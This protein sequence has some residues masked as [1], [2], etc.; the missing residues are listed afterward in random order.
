MA[1][2]RIGEVLL[3]RGLITAS[4]LDTALIH[5]RQSG[6]RLGTT[7]VAL[8]A[9]SE[10][11]LTAT[12]AEL[13]GVPAVDLAREVPDHRAIRLLRPAFCERHLVLPLGLHE[14][15]GGLVLRRGPGG[16]RLGPL[17]PPG[18][19]RDAC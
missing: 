9:L 14:G 1:R 3:E 8:G 4:Q 17:R 7:L 15:A 5:Q 11:R 10:N 6:G 12:L 18:D 16:Y 13:Q 2:K 19:S